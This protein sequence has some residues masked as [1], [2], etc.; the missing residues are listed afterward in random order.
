MRI[1]AAAHLAQ[2]GPRP[3]VRPRPFALRRA[4]AVRLASERMLPIIA[5]VVVLGA[6]IVSFQPAAAEGA[7]GSVSGPGSPV[8]L[9]VGGGASGQLDPAEIAAMND[10]GAAGAYQNAAAAPSFADDGTIY[11]PVAV[12]TALRDGKA[13]LQTY[14]VRAGD[15]LTGIASRYGL[16]MM[17]LWWANALT[18]KDQLHVGQRLVIPPVDGLVITVG[19]GDTLASLAAKYKVQATDILAVN[20]I[21]DPNLIIGQT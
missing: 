1:A 15:T 16:S 18:A 7:T 19:D 3:V 13:L 9:A 4:V 8:R 12:D 6:S 5:A 11:K 17:T 21:E 20:Q 10:T 14:T 2:L